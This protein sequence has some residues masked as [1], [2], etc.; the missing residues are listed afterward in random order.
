NGGQYASSP[1]VPVAIGSV[2]PVD[3]WLFDE[4][5][6]TTVKD[7]GTPGG[8]DGTLNGQQGGTPPAFVAG[9]AGTA[10]DKALQFNGTGAEFDQTSG[11]VSVKDLAPVLGT[12]A[13]LVAW[14]NTTQ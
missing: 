10:S 2:P 8:N 11:I 1:I 14:I 3:Q 13:S 5:S 12:T 9:P 7:T 6:G 4:G